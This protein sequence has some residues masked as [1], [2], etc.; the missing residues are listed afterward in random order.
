MFQRLHLKQGA[1]PQGG[2]VVPAM[3]V[4]GRHDRGLCEDRRHGHASHAAAQPGLEASE[5][6][7]EAVCLENIN[8]G[9]NRE[10]GMF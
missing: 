5:G 7:L 4:R 3:Q 10:A 8:G 9:V 2:M 6:T 1:P